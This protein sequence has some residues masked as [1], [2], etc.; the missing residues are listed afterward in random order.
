MQVLGAI[1]DYLTLTDNQFFTEHD[2]W[3]CVKEV[4]QQALI[5]FVRTKTGFNIQLDLEIH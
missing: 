3:S 2:G 1:T 5:D 4:D